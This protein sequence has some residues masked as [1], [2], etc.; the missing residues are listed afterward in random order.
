MINLDTL[1][2]GSGPSGIGCAI[3]LK[4]AGVNVAIIERSTPG[5]KVNICPRV[6]NYPGFSKIP[7]PDLAF[8][9]FQRIGENKIPLIQ[10]E[11]LDFTKNSDDTF[12]VKTNK[13]EILTKT[14]YI[15]SGTNERK[16]GL[17]NEDKLFAHGV[18]YCAVCDGHFFKGQDVIVIG[19]GNAALKEAIYMCDIA[20]HVYLI[21]RRNQFR[22]NLKVVE[23]LQGCK[24]ATILTPYVPI[25]FLGED[26]VTGIVIK[27]VETNEEKTIELQGI[28]PLVG[29]NPNTEFV[30]MNNIKNEWGNIPVDKNMMTGVSGV[31]AGGDVLPRDIRQIYLSEIDGKRA[32]KAIIE[33][34]YK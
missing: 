21:H 23:E 20:S 3:E 27:N 33:Y 17:E 8:A 2:I 7:G 16:L 24:N 5:G 6:D 10:E 25:K 9:L 13:Q 31:F 34:L 15:A 14:I 1:V 28:F 4:K 32:S 26:K 22:G 11:V 18:S 19:G 29:Q 30:H 12:L